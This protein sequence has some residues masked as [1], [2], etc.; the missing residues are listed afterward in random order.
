MVWYFNCS[1]MDLTVPCY[2]NFGGVYEQA[3]SKIKD[4]ENGVCL[5][6]KKSNPHPV[7]KEIS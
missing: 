1:F 7:W 3:S 6:T 2:C 4:T 5:S